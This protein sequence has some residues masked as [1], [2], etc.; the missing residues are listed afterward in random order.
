MIHRMILKDIWCVI[1][2]ICKYNYKW[3][4]SIANIMKINKWYKL[5]KIIIPNYYY[6]HKAFKILND[7]LNFLLKFWLDK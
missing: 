1:I 2:T 3:Y 4:S 6:I 7:F 5:M